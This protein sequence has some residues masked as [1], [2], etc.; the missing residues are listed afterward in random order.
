M[1][2][3]FWT[4]LVVIILISSLMACKPQMPGELR[5]ITINLTYIPN[6]Q[7]APF[8][9][10]MEKGFF[11]NEGLKVNLNYGN[12]ADL[13]ALVGAG[14][15]ELMI[16]SGEQ[17]LLSRAQGLP[18]VY[19][20]AW[21]K[22]YPVGV[23]SLKEKSIQSPQDLVGKSV[24]IPGLYGA[25]YIG[26]EA[27]LRSS[28]LED[29]DVELRSIGYTQV[30]AISTGQVDSAV[31]YVANE[32]NVLSSLGYDIDLMRV[33]DYLNLVGNG[34]VT[35]QKTVAEDP[36]LIKK[37]I[38]GLIKA[39][40]DI[41]S[42]PNEA[43]EICKIYVENLENADEKVQKAVLIDSVALWQMDPSGYSSY[44]SWDN[45]QKLLLE[46]D[47]MQAQIEIDEVFT[48]EFLP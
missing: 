48:N 5:P 32:P 4:L 28:G 23:I 10:A 26:F 42:D 24:G 8:Y 29:K 41:Q 20:M 1:K 30:E 13:V 2:N 6:V 44:E 18:V 14:D 25:S 21:Y 11:E 27:L 46:M 43:Y 37:V 16:A 36:D 35:N 45:M 38:I 17:V 47:L 33:S 12:E 40:K 3:F 9:V 39:M 19:V 15:Q 34:L 31:I 22:D 7:F